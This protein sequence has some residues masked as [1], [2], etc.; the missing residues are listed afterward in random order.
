MKE[1]T[2]TYS[3]CRFCCLLFCKLYCRLSIR[4]REH[5]PAEGGVI[6]ACNHV[7]NLDPIVLGVGSQRHVG[8]MAKRELFAVPFLGRLLK[9]LLVIPLKRESADRS[10]IK[11]SIRRLRQGHVVALFPEGTRVKPEEVVAAKAGVGFLAQTLGVPVI[12]AYIRG[13][14]AA[15]PRGAVFP[16][17]HTVAITFGERIAIDASAT[18]AEAAE[19]V[20]ASIRRLSRCAI[21]ENSVLRSACAEI[22]D[23]KKE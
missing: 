5:I 19:Q 2:R 12:P 1:G 4:G 7:S 3:F 15:W 17:P 20:M 13:T 10:A 8:F 22:N 6:L 18:Y 23:A 21:L 9:L 11:E 16:R 14:D